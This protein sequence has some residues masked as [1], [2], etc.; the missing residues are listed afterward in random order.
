MS[1]YFV[2]MVG[3]PA[4][5]KSYYANVYKDAQWHM[6]PFFIENEKTRNKYVSLWGEGVL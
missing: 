1:Q 5:G 6:Q 2:M 3:L 4:S